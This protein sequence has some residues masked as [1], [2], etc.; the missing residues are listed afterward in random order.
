MAQGA[1]HIIDAL[2]VWLP[3]AYTVTM[4]TVRSEN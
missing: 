2:L 4:V 1:S 3:A